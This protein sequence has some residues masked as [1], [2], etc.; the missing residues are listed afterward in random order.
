MPR[1]QLPTLQFGLQW[2][3]DYTLLARV[4]YC[5]RAGGEF[6]QGGRKV[7][8]PLFDLYRLMQ[9]ILWPEDEH[10]AWSDLILQTI[11]DESITV[12]QGPKDTSKTRTMAKYALTDYFC[13]PDNTLILMSSTK[14]E[15]LELRGWG[16]VK[17]LYRRAQ[18]VWPDCPGYMVNSL[19]GVFTDAVGDNWEPRD[20]RKGIIGIPMVQANGDW[21]GLEEYTGIKQ[22]RR[23][24]I[25]DEVQFMKPPYLATLANL[26][27]GNFKGVFTGNP[28]G[29]NDPLDRL[30]EPKEGW[31]SIGE[32]TTTTTWKN[33]WGGVTIQL[34]GPDSPNIR[35]PGRYD[36]WM[37]G[38]ED[39]DFI[40]EH[41]GLE[42]AE[43]WNQA[44]GVR[45]PGISQRYVITPELVR[46]FGAQ[47]KVVWR[48]TQT[49]GGFALDASYGGDR[50]MGMPF[51]WGTD[52]NGLTVLRLFEPILVP[53]KVYGPKESVEDM[54]IAEDQIAT[55]VRDHCLKLNI[56]P[57]A[58][59]FDSTGRGALGTAF[60]RVWSADVNPIEF[61]GAPTARPVCSDMYKLDE[62]TKQR[63][64]VRADEHY[65]KFVTELYFSLRYAIE[66]RQIRMLPNSALEELRRR[67]WKLV[68]G[69]KKEIE[70]KLETKKKLGRSPDIADATVIACEGARRMGFLIKRLEAKPPEEDLRWQRTLRDRA[71]QLKKSYELTYTS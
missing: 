46:Q 61:G 43:Y 59:F 63:R 41:W 52:I 4:L 35:E 15:G 13:F 58:V 11:L 64:L 70:T 36:P 60:A 21:K 9:T 50:C 23:R 40:V 14:L 8:A 1:E 44:A 16:D 24:L 51:E 30:A 55:F 33:A 65:S 28:I 53:V 31:D 3:A 57:R 62:T 19:H 66:G 29:E 12:V 27:K 18:K 42:S 7:G 17:T 25:G 39:I 22:D 34:Y 26:K 54:M 48:G 10:H 47:E 45:R 2:S 49:F 20:L 38:Q 56:P 5:I 32:I 6:D 69:N 37:L 68:K 71:A 67:E